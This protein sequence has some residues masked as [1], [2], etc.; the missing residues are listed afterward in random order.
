M[1]SIID[2]IFDGEIDERNRIQKPIDLLKDKEYIAYEKLTESLSEEQK[3][4]L[5]E[6]VK[7][8]AIKEGDTFKGIY[9]R[10]FKLGLL[11]GLETAKFNPE[12]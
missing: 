3:E 9:S 11:I 2:Y 1:A 4:L 12:D 5:E 7:E 8:Q 10:G 6:F